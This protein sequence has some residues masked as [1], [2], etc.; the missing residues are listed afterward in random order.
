VATLS[1][2]DVDELFELR[3]VLEH[4]AVVK[5]LPGAGNLAG[6]RRELAA[7]RD[8]AAAGRAFE[9]ADAHRRFHVE[10]VRLA[11]RRQLLLAY[12]PI[13]MRLQLHMAMNLRREE[14]AASA[15]DGVRRHAALLDAVET[16]DPDAVLTA[17]A[18]HGAQTY[19]TPT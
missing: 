4:H 6:L 9:R 5:A 14:E 1:D 2:T 18:G 13:L 12:E 16:D 10:L 17:L 11:G 7:M 8:A 3:D 19:L 15:D